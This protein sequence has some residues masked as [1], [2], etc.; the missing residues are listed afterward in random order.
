MLN[1]SI[2]HGLDIGINT[3]TVHVV[4]DTVKT[5]FLTFNWHWNRLLDVERKNSSPY[6]KVCLHVWGEVKGQAREDGENLATRSLLTREQ[7]LFCY[8]PHSA[9]PASVTH[10][11]TYT[12][13]HTHTHYW[14]DKCV[15]Q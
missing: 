1:K 6:L 9:L 15:E 3:T 8:Y 10:T 13:T 7:E 4:T 11:H 2:N 14:H 12:H 5:T